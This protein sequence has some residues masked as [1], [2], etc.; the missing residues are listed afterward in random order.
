MSDGDGLGD[1]D[2][3]GDGRGSIAIRGDWWESSMVGGPS[4]SPSP[5][6]SRCRDQVWSS[7]ISYN[8]FLPSYVVARS[9]GSSSSR[10]RK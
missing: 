4:P 9:V 6:P 8:V 1:G 5:S 10:I 2:G 7:E 3:D